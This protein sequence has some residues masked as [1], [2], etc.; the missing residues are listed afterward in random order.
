MGSSNCHCS[1]A[2]H[3]RMSRRLCQV[4]AED[5]VRRT[6]R[7]GANDIAGIDVLESETHLVPKTGRD[8]FLQKSAD[9]PQGDVARRVAPA[10]A[11]Q[12]TL[13]GALRNDDNRGFPLGEPSAQVAVQAV[14]AFK[15]ER[16]LWDVRPDRSFN[17]R[18]G[19]V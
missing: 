4:A 12:V 15:I 19:P 8:P 2:R 13:A 11:L 5:R 18:R 14:V 17:G 6:G 1:P 3:A 7:R 16:D 10:K 9:I